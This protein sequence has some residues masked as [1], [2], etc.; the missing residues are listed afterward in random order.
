MTT[1]P[2]K[3]LDTFVLKTENCDI[4]SEIR[5][6]RAVDGTEMLDHYENRQHRSTI[7]ARRCTICNEVITADDVGGTCCPCAARPALDL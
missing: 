6:I 2:G 4:A 3:L 7:S 5:L 1:P